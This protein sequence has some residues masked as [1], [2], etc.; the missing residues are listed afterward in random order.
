MGTWLRRQGITQVHGVD[1]TPAMLQHA[2]AQRV[3]AQLCV[4]DITHCPLPD[5]GYDLGIAGLV[6][7]HVPD[8]RAFYTEAARLIR[9]GGFFVLLDY[10]PFCLLQGIPTHFDDATGESTAITNVVHLLSDHVQQSRDVNWVLLEMQER[11]VDDAWIAHRPGMARYRHQP[12]GFVMVWK[13]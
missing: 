8:L 11:L 9:P 6:T 10:H 1:C 3:Y 4:A 12:V 5:Q 2:A 13:T 7:C